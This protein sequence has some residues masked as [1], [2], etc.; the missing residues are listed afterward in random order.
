[1][2]FRLQLSESISI[3][4]GP[5]RTLKELGTRMRGDCSSSSIISH[6]RPK[7][8]KATAWVGRK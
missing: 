7:G 8:G 6:Y 1:M 3:T 4:S 5:M 2:V